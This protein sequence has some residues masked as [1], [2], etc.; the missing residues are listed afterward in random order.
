MQQNR[1]V[2]GHTPD[3][4]SLCEF[5]FYDPIWYYD[6][7]TFPEDKRYVGQWL[8]EAHKIGQ[9]MCYWVLT[10]T[11]KLIARST[12]QP[13]PDAEISP[14]SVKAE[15]KAFDKSINTKLPSNRKDLEGFEVPDYLQY[16]D[17]DQEDSKTPHYEPMEPEATMPEA[18][19]FT[20]EE[21]DKY[22]SA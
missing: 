8:G 18:D 13:I 2:Y 9:A 17:S 11:G 5:D 12:V 14:N 16:I 7:N 3:I 22:I 15:L 20:A 19:T 21:Y 6:P 1:W 10:S 4:S